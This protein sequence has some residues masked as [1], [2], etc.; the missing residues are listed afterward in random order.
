MPRTLPI[1]RS[2]GRTV[3]RTTSTTRLC[4]SSTT[5]VSTHVPY[6]KMPMNIRMMPALAKMTAVVCSS[7][8]GSRAEIVGGLR[9]AAS[10]PARSPMTAAAV[11]ALQLVVGPLED[12]Q[13]AR[14]GQVG[15][16]LERG[17]DRLGAQRLLGGGAVRHGADVEA[18]VVLVGDGHDLT[19]EAGRR[20][21]DQREIRLLFVAQEDRGQDE[22][23]GRAGTP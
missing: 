14:A 21:A 20:R 1:N 3:V 8:G 22:A 18:E 16:D 23:R 12:D 2:R 10:E 6:E 15:R 11:I 9:I 4:F 19:L 17:V 13:L 7:V 5:P